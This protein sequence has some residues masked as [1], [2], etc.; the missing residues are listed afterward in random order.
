MANLGAH[1]ST[2]GGLHTV[3]ERAG[4]AT[5]NVVQIFSKNQKQWQAKPLEVADIGRFKD[6]HRE[7]GDCPLIV[8][9]SYL[10]NM[11]SP[12]DTLW[13]KSIA[14]FAVELERCDQLGIPYL[15]THPGAHVGSGEEIGLERI[16]AALRRLLELGVGGDTT[17]LL[18]TTAGQGTALG[19]RFEHL[20]RLLELTDG[21]Q[22]VGVCLDTCHVLA[23][24]YDFR[25]PEQYAAMMAEFERHI[26]LD[27]L[28]AFH[29]ND[30]KTDL[31]SKVDRHTH[32]GEGFIGLE[33]FRSLLND[34]RFARHPMVLETPKEPDETADNKN[35]ATLR[36][37]RHEAAS[38]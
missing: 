22:R 14:A 30:S 12:D 9:D 17:I 27:R 35:L 3:F 32:I 18:E 26:G 33:G 16:G 34:Q 8:H 36:G 7:F 21:H 29:L 1:V 2:S 25:T 28:K 4:Q 13:E 37:L 11:A 20:G 15:V 24:G 6:A 23:A 5:C 19:H 38:V 31:G 10:I